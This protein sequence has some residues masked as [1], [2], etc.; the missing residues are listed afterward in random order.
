MFSVSS[1]PSCGRLS[2]FLHCII[3]SMLFFLGID[4]FDLQELFEGCAHIG[5][6]KI[7]NCVTVFL[8]SNMDIPTTQE[9]LFFR[10]VICAVIFSCGAMYVN[11]LLINSFFCVSNICGNYL[12]TL[13]V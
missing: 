4:C 9:T 8:N 1:F 6:H 12:I 11:V 2:L 7:E 5:F 3:R 10:L 13:S